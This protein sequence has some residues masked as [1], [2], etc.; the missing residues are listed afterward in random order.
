MLCVCYTQ[1][2]KS[3]CDPWGIVCCYFILF[4]LWLPC[5]EGGFLLFQ[6]FIDHTELH[7]WWS[8][9]WSFLLWGLYAI[10]KLLIYFF[11]TLHCSSNFHWSSRITHQMLLCMVTLLGGLYTVHRVH[12]LSF[13]NSAL[14]RRWHSAVPGFRC[15]V[16]WLVGWLVLFVFFW[17]DPKL[18]S[19]CLRYGL[20]VTETGTTPVCSLSQHCDA[21][22]SHRRPSTTSLPRWSH[23]SLSMSCYRGDSVVLVSLLHEGVLSAHFV[24]VVLCLLRQ[25][26]NFVCAEGYSRVMCFFN[27]CS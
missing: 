16:G 7:I 3:E 22:G 1:F 20:Y 24:I 21:E 8:D 2:L 9:A 13:Y 19:R 10:H 11:I 15:V 4:F 12:I 6:E 26:I 17:F 23:L 25:I 14:L 5:L 27:L 18:H